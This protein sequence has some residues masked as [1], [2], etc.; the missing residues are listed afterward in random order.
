MTLTL[1]K[2]GPGRHV[3]ATFSLLH[4]VCPMRDQVVT[5][6]RKTHLLGAIRRARLAVAVLKD[7]GIDAAALGASATAGKTDEALWEAFASN[8]HIRSYVEALQAEGVFELW[9]SSGYDAASLKASSPYLARFGPGHFYSA[10]PAA[11]QVLDRHRPTSL[12]G[13]ELD[14]DS[15][16][17]NAAELSAVELP[18]PRYHQDNDQFSLSDA[19]Q[20]HHILASKRPARF[21]EIG[22]GYSTAVV[23]DAVQAL[24]LETTVTCIEPYADRLRSQL[25]AGD[26]QRFTLVEQP[27]Q[28]VPLETF[29]ELQAGDVLF[30]DSTH[31]VAPGSDVVYELLEILPRLAAGVIVHVHDILY[32]FDIPDVW[33]DE[34][35]IWCEPYLLRALLTNSTRYQVTTWLS[36]LASERSDE[37]RGALSEDSAFGG[38]SLWLEIT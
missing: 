30:I 20:L 12:P 17:T 18:G 19:V 36:A 21:I 8:P 13:L 1:P 32:P 37:V 15:M 16:L 4:Y 28:S 6:L 35:R 10:L 7:G 29:D 22:S 9:M 11:S 5:V 14:F 26:E 23:L 3:L 34:G 31:V 24:N 2:M 33:L 38:S 27:V 25:L